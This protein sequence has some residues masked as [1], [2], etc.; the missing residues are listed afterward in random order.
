MAISASLLPP[1]VNAGLLSSYALLASIFS[2]IGTKSSKDID[3]ESMNSYLTVAKNCTAFV[4]NKYLPMYSC[5]MT[6]DAGLLGI[7]SFLLTL[8]NIICIIGRK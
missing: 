3:Y 5:D 8:V 2:S 7:C 4:E 6:T 1:A